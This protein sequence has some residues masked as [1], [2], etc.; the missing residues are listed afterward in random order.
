MKRFRSDGIRQSF[1]TSRPVHEQRMR[2][3]LLMVQQ[4]L[5]HTWRRLSPEERAREYP[6]EKVAQLLGKAT[7]PAGEQNPEEFE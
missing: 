4:D 7:Q 1:I 5:K 2:A 3:K 6:P